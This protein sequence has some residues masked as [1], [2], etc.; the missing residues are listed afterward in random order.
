MMSGVFEPLKLSFLH[1]SFPSS[2]LGETILILFTKNFCFH[3]KKFLY[4]IMRKILKNSSSASLSILHCRLTK[5]SHDGTSF[6]YYHVISQNAYL[7]VMLLNTVSVK[8]QYRSQELMTTRV[9]YFFLGTVIQFLPWISR[10]S[11][12]EFMFMRMGLWSH[13]RFYPLNNDK[14]LFNECII[15]LNM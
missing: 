14:H 5:C 9:F 8:I 3:M 15:W 10:I 1:K 13:I 4:C 6:Q 12:P 2:A 7:L 11:Q